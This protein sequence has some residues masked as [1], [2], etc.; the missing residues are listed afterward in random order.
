LPLVAGNLRRRASSACAPVAAAAKN[1]ADNNSLFIVSTNFITGSK[2]QKNVVLPAFPL[3]KTYF[4]YSIAI[5]SFMLILPV[6][7]VPVL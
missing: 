1:S 5:M 7:S 2:L 6:I 3:K 4:P